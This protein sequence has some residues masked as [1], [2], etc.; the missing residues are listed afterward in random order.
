MAMKHIVD[1]HALIWYWE[2]NPRLGA[3]AKT[4]LDDP[5]SELVMP[6]IALAEACW[7]VEHGKSSIA[8]QQDLLAAVD[9]DPR[10]IIIPLDRSILNKSLNI[11]IIPEMHDR[12]IT[13][14]C[15]AQQ[16]ETV[17]IL[18]RGPD[19]RAAGLVSIIW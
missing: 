11:G 3:K 13:A 14:L 18:T 16:G 9:A 12:L 6:I 5:T 15:L 17:A 4:V 1:A 2:G 8:T 19:I 7:V 10:L